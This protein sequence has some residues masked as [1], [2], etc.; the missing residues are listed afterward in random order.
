[1]ITQKYKVIDGIKTFNHKNYNDD[2]NPDNLIELYKQE[3]KHFWFITRKEFILKKISKVISIDKKI[4]E[5]GAGTGNI[6]KYLIKHGY[7]NISVGEMHLDGLKY[8][9]LYGIKDCYQFNL[10]NIPFEDEF[11]TIMMFDV[12]EH[13]EN[14]SLALKN[15]KQALKPKGIIALTVPAHM[16]LWSKNDTTAC[17]K[18]R[19]NKRELK[20]ILLK[21]GFDTL[22]I[23]YFFI[24][25]TPLLLLRRFI[26]RDT[27]Q[28]IEKT[29]EIK[30]NKY[31]N[32]AL[33]HISRFENRF[34]KFIPN[35]FGGSILVIARKK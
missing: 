4:I 33:L 29:K 23:N 22:T 16:W 17:H 32:Q 31:I 14:D 12:L 19:Y 15:I 1:L 27:P 18:R 7:K 10:L 28:N 13:L 26:N 3:E 20:S 2:Y 11:D 8:A 21:E 5:I 9:K 35:F 25:I 30:I 34:N 6:T 24:F